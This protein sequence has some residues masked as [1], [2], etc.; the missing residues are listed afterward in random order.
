M[1]NFGTKTERIGEININNNSKY[2][3]KIVEYI[4]EKKYYC[5]I[6]R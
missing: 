5:S 2:K 4:N 1:D 3:M 6:S